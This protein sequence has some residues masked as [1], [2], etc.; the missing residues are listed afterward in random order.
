[1]SSKSVRAHIYR[2][3]LVLILITLL[4]LCSCEGDNPAGDSHTGGS[5]A[6][7]VAYGGIM[8]EGSI[9]D[10]SNLIPILSSD[11]ASH[12]IAGLIFNGLVKYDKDMKVVGDLAE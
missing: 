6:D 4:P 3:M 10:A 1:M 2:I 8:V 11:S 12:S 9:G 5:S 7:S